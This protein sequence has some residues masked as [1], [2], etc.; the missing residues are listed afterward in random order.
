MKIGEIRYL[1]SLPLLSKSL[2]SYNIETNVY[3]LKAL[4][5]G[6]YYRKVF[7][8]ENDET[9]LITEG[10]DIVTYIE[11]LFSRGDRIFSFNNIITEFEN[12]YEGH[13]N[14]FLD[15]NTFENAY[16][17]KILL[18]KNLHKVFDK[19]IANIEKKREKTFNFELSELVLNFTD[20]NP[21]YF[22]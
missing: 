17:S 3:E 20:K 7:R 9:V 12:K 10:D 22:V 15:F 16:A 5:N 14:R 1:I 19:E 11:P 21:Q 4:G 13:T 2:K 6:K 18:L 8:V